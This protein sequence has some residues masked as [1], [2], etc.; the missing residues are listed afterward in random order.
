[1]DRHAFARGGVAALLAASAVVAAPW[2]ASAAENRP[3]SQPVLSELTTEDEPCV[4]GADRPYVSTRPTLR[5]V[6]RDPDG[7][8]VTAEFE[9][10]WTDSAGVRQVRSAVGSIARSSGS[11]FSWPVPT[12]VPAFTGVS[13]RVRAGA[14]GCGRVRAG[15]GG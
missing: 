10:S 5:A 12:D 6:L 4:G 15:A 2:A 14:G 1:M 7:G 8:R 13:W 11:A 9:V 3:P